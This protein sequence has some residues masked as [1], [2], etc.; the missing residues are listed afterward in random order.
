MNIL[1]HF[2]KPL[3]KKQL[4][5]NPQCKN[6]KFYLKTH[7]NPFLNE[8]LKFKRISENK[9]YYEYAEVCRTQNDM[10]GELGYYFEEKSETYSIYR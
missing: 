8:C 5:T 6:C 2:I 9:Q 1:C 10:C 3:P 4:T 7:S